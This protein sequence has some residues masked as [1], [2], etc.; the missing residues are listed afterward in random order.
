MIKVTYYFEDKSTVM[1]VEYYEDSQAA[2]VQ[3]D[4]EEHGKEFTKIENVSA[5]DEEYLIHKAAM[6]KLRK[7]L[8]KARELDDA[9]LEE[10][11]KDLPPHKFSE[12]FERKMA[13]LFNK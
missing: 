8:I 10:E 11:M 1:D 4:V 9:R 3:E 13:A 7:S 5:D 2:E 6:E 12:E